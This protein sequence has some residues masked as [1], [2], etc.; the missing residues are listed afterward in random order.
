MKK[1]GNLYVLALPITRREKVKKI[2][3]IIIPETVRT[4]VTLMEGEVK[5]V[6]NGTPMIPMEVKP[7][8]HIMY[9]YNE[10]RPVIDEM[11]LIQVD[12]IYL[13]V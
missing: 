3:S 10:N 12:D 11:V 4:K 7:G 13:V 1:V 9:M 2:G 8:D 6:G 5:A